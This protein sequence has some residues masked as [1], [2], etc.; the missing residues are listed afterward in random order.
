MLRKPVELSLQTYEVLLE[1]L[2]LGDIHP[3]LV[4]GALW[5]SPDERKQLAADTDAE[6]NRRW[7]VRG[8]R[9]DDDFVEVLRLL[10]RPGVEYYS[11]VKSDKGERTVRA[12]GSGRDA[13]TVVAVDQVLYI[14]P[15]SAEALAREFALLLPEAPPARI[16]SLNCSD[17]DFN[18]I[19]SGVI[20]SKTS[21][22]IRDAKQVVQWLRAPKTYFGRLYVAVRDSRG[23]RLRNENPP[24]WI[25]TE[26]GRILFGVDKSGWISLAGAG[27]QDLVKKVQQ[28]E[29]ELRSGR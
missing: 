19:K 16:A 12:A 10:Q 14:A 11:W 25:D 15:C 27:P 7:L 9:L 13:V 17:A 1:R 24:G 2:N 28:L 4:R 6:L 8:G 20:P 29:N 3:T 5:Y 18:A 26:Q 23:K 22:S 21:P